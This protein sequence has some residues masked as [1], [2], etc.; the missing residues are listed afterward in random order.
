MPGEGNFFNDNNL[1]PLRQNFS[2]V[3]GSAKK[4]EELLNQDITIS[5]NDVMEFKGIHCDE[6]A[7]IKSI[8]REEFLP[9]LEGNIIDVGGGTADIL[10]EVLPEGD[11]THLDVLDF[12]QIKIP[13]AHKRI[14]GDFFDDKIIEKLTPIDT[15]FMSHVQQFIDSDLEKLRVAIEKINAKRIV[16]VEDMNDDFLGE[17]M[18]FSLQ[19]FPGANPEIKID[20]FPYKYNKVKSAPFTATLSSPNFSEL[21]KQC[22]YLMDV[23]HTE[24]NIKKMS[25]FLEQKLQSPT[26]TIN[27]EINV[28][29]K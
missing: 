12:S 4:E 11:V 10:S 1:N 25:E 9:Y 23:S 17:V 22:L 27:Q 21:T 20:G 13:D 7:I 26:F 14:T 16:L 2:T 3:P 5:A 29:E 19:N 15:L 28:Y 18:R 8:L 6:N 24:E